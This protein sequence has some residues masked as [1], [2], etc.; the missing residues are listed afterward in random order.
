MFIDYDLE[1]LEH[2]DRDTLLDYSRQFQN[3]S[4][5]IGLSEEKISFYQKLSVI[6]YMWLNPSSKDFPLD[7]VWKE[8]DGRGPCPG[9]LS[10]DDLFLLKK[11]L[12]IIKSLR[13]KAHFADI[14]WLRNNEHKMAVYASEHYLQFFLNKDKEL[15]ISESWRHA[16]DELQRGLQIA[17]QIRHKLLINSYKE[18]LLERF[19]R[20]RE[21]TIQSDARYCYDLLYISHKFRIIDT[22]T[23]SSLAESFAHLLQNTPEQDYCEL[24]FDFAI[25]ICN[26]R[27]DCEKFRKL[28]CE[29]GIWLMSQAGS[30]RYYSTLTNAVH[31]LRKGHAP[32]EQIQKA[33]DLLLKKQQNLIDIFKPLE[34]SVD[35]RPF[36][37]N[38]TKRSLSCKKLNLALYKFTIEHPLISYK[39]ENENILNLIKKDPL[40]FIIPC[41]VYDNHGRTVCQI[42]SL[43]PNSAKYDQNVIEKHIFFRLARII[44]SRRCHEFI[45]P[46]IDILTKEHKITKSNLF[47]FINKNPVIPPNHEEFIL[48][49]IL[50]GFRHKMT[51]SMHL[52]IPQFEAVIRH[53]LN[54]K[55]IVTSKLNDNDIQEERLLA[56]LLAMPDAE[57]IFG[58]DFIFEL[59][60]LL[61]EKTGYNFRNELVHGFLNASELKS[62]P[63]Y[64]IWWIFFRL[65][66]SG[67]YNK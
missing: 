44:W 63:S 29:A 51:I 7:S 8:K 66:I 9:D 30:E 55:K 50:A 41:S 13:L 22:S 37:I 48:D 25:Q 23:L 62:I 20:I 39:N 61:C 12:P 1:F 14:L 45:L 42:P 46:G 65:L 4:K 31:H 5:E 17:R 57:K 28:H 54:T 35:I 6:T 56:P 18:C 52:L 58:K 24:Y 43:D 60:G 15:G 27:K 47:R 32:K 38:K 36:I 40:L 21:K 64:N 53:V 3:K 10:Q 2:K 59:R 19:K 11:L 33:H 16:T 49:G 26:A 67:H 34:I